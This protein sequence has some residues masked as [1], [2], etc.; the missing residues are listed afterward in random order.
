MTTIQ[1][2]CGSSSE[3]HTDLREWM[4]S[5]HW[6]IP[7]WNTLAFLKWVWG[8]PG[9]YQTVLTTLTHGLF[10]DGLLVEK[11]SRLSNHSHH[12]HPY[13]PRSS[14]YVES[15]HSNE[16][17]KL[18]KK[19]QLCDSFVVAKIF[20]PAISGE[21]YNFNGSAVHLQSFCYGLSV[22]LSAVRLNEK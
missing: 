7:R 13:R 2:A 3:L 6:K 22:S 19:R 18:W 12:T 15:N 11:G 1:E 10:A 9:L 14:W 5:N 4:T 16:K 17:N 8:A 20:K 21:R